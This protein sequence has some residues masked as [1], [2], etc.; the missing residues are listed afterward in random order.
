MLTGVRHNFLDYLFCF[1]FF[2]IIE[3]VNTDKNR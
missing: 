1:F 2:I 3:T